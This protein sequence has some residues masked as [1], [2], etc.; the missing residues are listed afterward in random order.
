ME[1]QIDFIVTMHDEAGGNDYAF[2]DY[3]DKD[4]GVGRFPILGSLHSI[5]TLLAC[6]SIIAFSYSLIWFPALC[7][8]GG[9]LQ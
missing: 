1:I 8:G 7:S 9:S 4:A 6:A 5:K 2:H 3:E